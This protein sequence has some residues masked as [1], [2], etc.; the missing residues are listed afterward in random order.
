MAP[1]IGSFGKILLFTNVCSLFEGRKK[2]NTHNMI[3]LYLRAGDSGKLLPS[4]FL[5]GQGGKSS[6]L[7]KER[8]WL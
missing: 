6:Y 5:K 4:L 3:L 8:K 2:R 1:E 7:T